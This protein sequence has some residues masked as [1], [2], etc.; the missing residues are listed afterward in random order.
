M[1]LFADT[2][3]LAITATV[4]LTLTWAQVQTALSALLGLC[5]TNPSRDTSQ[6]G[7]AFYSPPPPP[8]ALD[9]P[10]RSGKKKKQRR[11]GKRDGGL[12]GEYLSKRTLSL[13]PPY[14]TLLVNVGV[15]TIL[16]P[17][18]LPTLFLLPC[19]FD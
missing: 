13:S 2:C 16:I 9:P 14:V 3:T 18:H 5:V 8:S 15:Y 12:S 17:L 6:G 4:T 7:R 1:F 11:E 10:Q 19:P